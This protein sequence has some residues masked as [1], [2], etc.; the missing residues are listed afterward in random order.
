MLCVDEQDG[1][2]STSAVSR[3]IEHRLAI[4]QV[5]Q[6]QGAILSHQPVYGHLGA[7]SST[8]LILRYCV[9]CGEPATEPCNAVATRDVGE[10]RSYPPPVN[11]ER[12]SLPAYV[13]IDALTLELEGGELAGLRMF[14]G[15]LD[16]DVF[17]HFTPPAWFQNGGSQR[18]PSGRC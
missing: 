11:E 3:L 14:A 8:G 5:Q 4:E 15:H 6:V 16:G 2:A 9:T 17:G 13:D 10:R 7:G 1:G 18:Q 12:H